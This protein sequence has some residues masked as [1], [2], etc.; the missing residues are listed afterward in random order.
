MDVWAMTRT[1]VKVCGICTLTDA[2]Y[3]VTAG[4]DAIGMV[5][6]PKSPRHVSVSTAKN[7]AASLPPFVS[8]VGLFVNSS[9]Q[10]ISNVL[11][12]VQLDLLQFHGDEDEAFCNSFNRPYIKAVRVKAETDLYQLCKQYDSAR[13]ILLDSYKQGVPGGTGETFDWNIIPHDLP[14]PVILAGGLDGNNVAQ[15]ISTAKPWAVDVSSGVEES[16]GKKDQ[17]KIVQFFRAAESLNQI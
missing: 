5:F 7:I 11:S 8:A 13:G 6:Y 12:E 17:Q 3:A 4:A 9:H 1:R 2:G 16:P 10:D 15:A 14:L